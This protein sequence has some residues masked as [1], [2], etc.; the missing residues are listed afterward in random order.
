MTSLDVLDDF[1]GG[2]P[3]AGAAKSLTLSQIDELGEM[4]NT[5]A[6]RLSRMQP[7]TELIGDLV[8]PGGWLGN[9]WQDEIFRNELNCA[10]LYEP[11]LL[12][13]DPL[14]EYFFS[15]FNLL[16]EVAL[17][18]R[19]GTQV[20]AGARMWANHGRRVHRGD[21]VEGIRAD[22][23]SILGVLNLFEPLIRS[24]VIVMRSQFPILERERH[25]LAASVRA[26]LRSA[27]TVATVARTEGL[28]LP[29]WDNLRGLQVTPPGG[30]LD[31]NDRAQ[32][33][34]EFYYL[35]KTLMFSRSAAALYAPASD[36]ELA[37]LQTKSA[38]YLKGKRSFAPSQPLIQEA[39]RTMAPDMRLD[40]VTAVKVR[41][42]EEAF[43]AWRQELRTL[44]RASV[45]VADADVPQLVKDM[46]QP[47][48]DEVW[49]AVSKSA[50]LSRR[51]PKNLGLALIT[52]IGAL[53]GG[54]AAAAAAAAATGVGGYLMDTF[55][56]RQLDGSK[57]VIA[58]LLHQN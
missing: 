27:P 14:A 9:G 13:H 57:P 58:A 46:M 22:L 55:V 26:D 51:A 29:R 10:L 52:G 1:F 19:G 33:E 17:E 45:G 8:Y 49:K 5:T 21:D 12:V 28:P 35:A 44:Q 37:L 34:P 42:S 54:L 6:A 32:W 24:G 38:E 23:D 40:P 7:S 15:D 30:L 39:L 25:A 11:R 50:V 36:N 18:G 47:K 31:P 3:G 56:R 48:V 53:P 4:V 20:V 2:L 41:S 16:P 43:N